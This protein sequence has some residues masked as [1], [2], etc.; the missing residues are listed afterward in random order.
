MSLEQ[1]RILLVEDDAS[2]RNLLCEELEA[3]GYGVEAVANCSDAMAAAGANLPDLVVSDLRLPD[4]DGLTLLQRLR[5]EGHALPFIIITAFGTVGQAVDALKAGAD[6]FLTKPLS[7]DHLRLKVRRLLA[8]AATVSELAEY[9]SRQDQSS[10]DDL[11]GESPQM[12]SLRKQITQIARSEAAVLVTGESGTG[13]ELVARAIHRASDRREGPFL[14]V[15]CAGIPHDLMESEFFGHEQGAFTGARQ[16]RRG[17]FAEAAGGT[18]LL[19]EIGEMPLSL[20]A[21]LLRVLQEHRVKAVGSDR[22]EAVDVRIVAATHV[23]L[24]KAVEEGWFR[25]DLYY[26]LET[27]A[28]AVPPLRERGDDI[29]LLA[30]KFLGQAAARHGRGF[31]RLGE[32]A[33]QI[34]ADYPFP[35][36]IRELASAIER[37]VTFC[38]GDVIRPE[39]L[40]VRIRQ[41]SLPATSLHEQRPG[42]NLA[43]WPTLEQV[44]QSYVR[45]VI[46]A[47]DSNKRRAAQIL[48][49]NRRT[50]YRWLED[51]GGEGENP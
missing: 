19:D 42:G 34:L 20:Q 50:L 18:L 27:L 3:E 33:G 45:E 43:E 5:S 31:I 47:V 29:E 14:P 51:S 23:D 12:A 13:K 35:G 4:Q 25:E 49:V 30:M 6:D 36:N 7:I 21:K 16:A 39:H 24:L 37:A 9:K 8:H 15:N 22:E 26:R 46:A 11:L 1:P 38:E 32:Q 28:L 10:R 2:L 48:G 40:P 17:L 44:Q 41:R